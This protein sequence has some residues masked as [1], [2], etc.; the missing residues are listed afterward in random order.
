MT[1]IDEERKVT[2]NSKTILPHRNQ[3]GE[4]ILFVLGQAKGPIKST[5]LDYEVM[6]HLKL[7]EA[8]RT[9]IR[10]QNRTQVSYELAWSRTTLKAQGLIY[11]PRSRHWS[12]V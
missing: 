12:L 11:Q 6:N 5:E 7:T 9:L 10:S 8:Q 4:A 1:S 2:E 3:L